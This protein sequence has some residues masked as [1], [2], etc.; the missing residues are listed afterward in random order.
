MTPEKYEA[1]L[2]E[3]VQRQARDQLAAQWETL[4]LLFDRAREASDA[5][6]T[7]PEVRLDRLTEEEKHALSDFFDRDGRA[8]G[9]RDA[10][11]T[12]IV[13]FFD[14]MFK[15]LHMFYNRIPRRAPITVGVDNIDLGTI[16]RHTANNV[17]H[18]LDWRVP[19][20]RLTHPDMAVA[21]ATTIARLMDRDPPTRETVA[22][23]ANNW[24]W[25]V[26][27]KISGR[28]F[29]VLME[30]V[31]SALNEMLSNAWETGRYT[32]TP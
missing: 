26:L 32:S 11:A 19:P 3:V 27:A 8:R 20:S 29:D 30:M 18:Y 31:E 23:W 1:Q 13:S 15:E 7:F 14:L 25:P 24:A 16:F 10:F 2:F 28:N 6:P 17:R 5:L 4:R 9:A 22:V 12:A 21:A